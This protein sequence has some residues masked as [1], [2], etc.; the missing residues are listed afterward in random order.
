MVNDAAF[1]AMEEN[2]RV[3]GDRA[4]GLGE[5][6]ETLRSLRRSAPRPPR[7]PAAPLPALTEREL[8]ILRLIAEGHDNE[9]IAA[10]LH[11]GFGTIKLHVR[12]I[13]EKLGAR[14]RTAAAVRAVR[15]GLI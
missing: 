9:E 3:F 13:L 12:G 6:L 11:F 5:S 8:E 7:S 1:K 14:T 4:R 15:L 10:S 2:L